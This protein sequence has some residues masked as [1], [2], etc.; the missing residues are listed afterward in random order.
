MAGGTVPVPVWYGKVTWYRYQ[1]FGLSSAVS[2]Q[3]EVSTSTLPTVPYLVC[4]LPIAY[5]LRNYSPPRTC[6][7]FSALKYKV[8]AKRI[9]QYQVFL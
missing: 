4:L 3:S 7:P 9:V 2:K 8:C 5:A 6:S 1:Y